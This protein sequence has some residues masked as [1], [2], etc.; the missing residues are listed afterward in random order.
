MDLLRNIHTF[1][2]VADAMSYTSAARSLDIST[3]AVSRLVSELEQ[4]LET[5]LFHR[6]TRQIVLTTAGQRYLARCRAILEALGNAE[7][8]ARSVH[9]RPTGHLRVQAS[10]SLGPHLLVPAIESYRR[11]YPDV[12]IK[13]M[14]APV[15][16]HTLDAG[17][18]IAILALP[19][20]RDSSSVGVQLGQTCSVLCAAPGY[21][22]KHPAPLTPAELASHPFIGYSPGMAETI[23]LEL[24]GPHGCDRATVKP[25]FCVNSSATAARALELHMG[26]GALP[27]HTAAEAFQA[28]RLVRVLAPWRLE[29]LN[30]YALF[31]SKHFLD[32]KARTWLDHLKVFF[33]EVCKQHDAVLNATEPS[34]S[35]SMRT[36]RADVVLHVAHS[37]GA[38]ALAARND[39]GD[40][41]GHVQQHHCAD[42]AEQPST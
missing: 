27:L 13:L 35:P 14:L 25:A 31:A 5:R 23:E 18:D 16:S 7:A 8:E 11:V 20:L 26:I 9:I 10:H 32:A 17:F 38:P 15:S 29:R 2:R 41:L 37:L 3:G 1:V 28:G 34:A 22:D 39:R 12:Q 6:T 42:V 19:E 24:Q 4:H 30:I 40:T 21:L 36:G 33:G